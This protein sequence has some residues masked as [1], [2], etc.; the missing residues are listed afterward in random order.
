MKNVHQTNLETKKKKKKR[1][2]ALYNQWIHLLQGYLLPRWDQDP[3]NN[4]LEALRIAKGPWGQ[5]YN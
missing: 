3:M 4:D 2:L 1:K 5:F